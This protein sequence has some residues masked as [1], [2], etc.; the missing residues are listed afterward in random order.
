MR[1]QPLGIDSVDIRIE[2]VAVNMISVS[3]CSGRYLDTALLVDRVIPNAGF[4][5]IPA[6]SDQQW[7]NIH[8]Q[9]S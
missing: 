6:I 5:A 8:F 4:S 9:E 3:K 2:K 7:E 1:Y